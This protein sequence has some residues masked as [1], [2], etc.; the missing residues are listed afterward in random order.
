[1]LLLGVLAAVPA[2][3]IPSLLSS[4]TSLQ[5]L[6]QELLVTMQSAGAVPVFRLGSYEVALD[7]LLIQLNNALQ[8]GLSTLAAG[9]FSLAVDLTT[10]LLILVYALV[11]AFWLLRDG[12]RLQR[13][14]LAR[15]PPEYQN[16]AVQLGRQLRDTWDGFLQGQLVLALAMGLIVWVVMGIVGL[17]NLGGLVLLAAV[18]EFLPSVGPTISGAVGTVVALVQGSLWLPTP[19]LPFAVMVGVLYLVIAQIENIFLVPRLVGGRVKLDATVALLGIISATVVFGALGVLLATPVMASLR[20]VL[21]YL[22][23]KLTDRE[24][25]AAHPP[26]DTGVRIPGI[27]RGRQIHGVIF[28][29]DGTLAALDRGAAD[30]LVEHTMWAER[31]LPAGE[32]LALARQWMRAGES[33]INRWIGLLRWLGRD[34]SWSL[35]SWLRGHP[36]LAQLTP[37]PGTDSIMATLLREY[38]VA[39]ISTRSHAEIEIFLQN[40]PLSRASLILVGGDEVRQ[41][42]PHAESV[43]VALARLALPAEQVLMVADS[44][45]Q[46]RPAHLLGVLTA[47]VCTGLADRHHLREADLVLADLAE[48]EAR[49]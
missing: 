3:F 39:I 38:R 23:R 26:E 12:P 22:Y 9:L 42:P 13:F 31:Y 14:L 49:L 8:Q 17:P 2:L 1:M 27:V 24:P 43:K 41:W 10:G 20:I 16:D 44:E 7:G 47:G 28:D 46:L 36:S 18:M 32:R 19:N 45:I 37:Q 35:Y 6:F 4:L 34:P 33:L 48:L 21:V 15:I 11:L 40:L 25:F 30:W 5:N 29:L